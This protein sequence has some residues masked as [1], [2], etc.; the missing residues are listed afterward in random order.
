MCVPQIHYSITHSHTKPARP[1][2]L[3]NSPSPQ[4]T[5]SGTLP[6]SY[7]NTLAS[8][9]YPYS[10]SSA[11][12]VKVNFKR[13]NPQE[14]PTCLFRKVVKVVSELHS[15]SVDVFRTLGILLEPY[16]RFRNGCWICRC[17]DAKF[18]K[19]LWIDSKRRR[20][21]AYVDST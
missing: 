3:N 16:L 13:S 20:L 14:H 11:R 18:S 15:H 2:H 21:L 8:R 7:S 12:E 9:G 5:H 10:N 1:S 19:C 17:F 6:E 4:L